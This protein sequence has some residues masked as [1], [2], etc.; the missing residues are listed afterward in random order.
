MHYNRLL[1]SKSKGNVAVVTFLPVPQPGV[2]ELVES[3]EVI[4][5][6]DD[7]FKIVNNTFNLPKLLRANSIILSKPNMSQRVGSL[8]T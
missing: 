5:S 7:M 4:A 1:S 8:V 6:R 3:A 2:S